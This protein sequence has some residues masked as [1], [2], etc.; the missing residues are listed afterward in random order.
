MLF[1]ASCSSVIIRHVMALPGSDRDKTQEQLIS[2]LEK[3]RE[4]VARL[5]VIANSGIVHNLAYFRERLAEEVSRSSRYK[6]NFS[7]VIVEADTFDAYSKKCGSAAGDE[8][9]GMLQTILRNA[10]RLSTSTAILK[11]AGSVFCCR[12]LMATAPAPWP[13]G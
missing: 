11:V 6:Y 3:M 7:I 10:L 12:I 4:Q 1:H 13:D 9:M 5:K 8:L 2:E